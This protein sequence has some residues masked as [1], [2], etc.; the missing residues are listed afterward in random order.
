MHRACTFVI[1]QQGDGE[2]KEVISKICDIY[3]QGIKRTKL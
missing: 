3:Q 1:C 2:K